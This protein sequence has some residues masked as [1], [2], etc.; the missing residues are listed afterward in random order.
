MPI[1][2]TK[3]SLNGQL[4]PPS[5]ILTLFRKNYHHLPLPL[6]I[7]FNVQFLTY[8][9]ECIT[10]IKFCFQG[11]FINLFV[12]SVSITKF[13]ISIWRWTSSYRLP[14]V[15]LVLGFGIPR[16]RENIYVQAAVNIRNFISLF[17]GQA[18]ELDFLAGTTSLALAG[19]Y[20]CQARL[21]LRFLRRLS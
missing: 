16:L 15:N 10:Y 8:L 5:N 6:F 21:D 1:K 3:S 4:P 18:F 14:E 13:F 17:S 19:T 11:W 7:T 12:A 20:C 9:I 2:E